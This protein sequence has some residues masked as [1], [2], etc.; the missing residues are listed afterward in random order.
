MNY[1]VKYFLLIIFNKRYMHNNKVTA[2]VPK[3]AI[4]VE[5]QREVKFIP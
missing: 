3:I 2:S 1:V 4:P 5:D